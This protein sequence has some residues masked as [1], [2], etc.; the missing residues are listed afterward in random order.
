MHVI[1][2]SLSLSLSLTFTLK[3]T[4]C[5]H[6]D[7]E[8][9]MAVVD[10]IIVVY[11]QRRRDQV[12]YLNRMNDTKKGLITMSITSSFLILDIN[13]SLKLHLRRVFEE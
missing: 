7:N 4:L 9:G 13:V 8:K 1:L 3:D 10:E 6:R 2:I 12:R 5:I 11:I